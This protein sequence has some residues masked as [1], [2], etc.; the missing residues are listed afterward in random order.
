MAYLLLIPSDL[1]PSCAATCSNSNIS[2]D[3]SEEDDQPPQLVSGCFEGGDT[4]AAMC[5]KADDDDQAHG[6]HIMEI[7]D[8]VQS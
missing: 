3:D 1:V 6:A 5:I 4:M 8:M 7:H 2:A